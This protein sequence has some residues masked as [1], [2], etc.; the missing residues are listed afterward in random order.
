MDE[1]SCL[2]CYHCEK[3]VAGHVTA[4]MYLRAK[5]EGRIPEEWFTSAGVNCVDCY[6][7]QKCVTDQQGRGSQGLPE[8]SYFL[9]LTNDCNLRC[10]YCYATKKPIV[11]T[12]AMLEQLRIFLTEEEDKRLGDHSLNIQFF[13]GEPTIEWE[14]LTWFVENFSAY[15][16]KLHP[17]RKVRWGMTTNATLLNSERLEFLKKWNMQPLLS[18][19]GRPETHDHHRKTVGGGGSHHLIPLDLILKYFP[20]PEIR[21]TITPDTIEDW[22]ADLRWFH[23]KGLYIV[24]TE[25]AYEADWTDEK[26]EIARQVYKKLADI[27]VERRR[28]GL[29]VWMKFIEDGL[30]FLSSDK[31]T[32]YVCGIA[33]GLMAIDASG[34]IY[35]CQRYASFSRPE[36]A[37]GDIW[38][39]FDEHKLAWTQELKREDMFPDPKSGFNCDDCIA[40]WSCR[41]GCNAMNFQC[42]GDRRM[43]L[44]SHC[45][46]HRMWAEIALIALARTGELWGKKYNKQSACEDQP[47][48]EKVDETNV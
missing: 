47:K 26:M 7:C 45:K 3:G 9:F 38:K 36:L 23:D 20:T 30:G 8:V 15:Y 19:D 40:R 27:Y 14:N 35:A 43:I 4:E 12:H 29:P 18:I 39:G 13:G 32:G 21:P 25:V 33:R 24:A 42:N 48:K 31:Q 17:G 37:I 28:A 2:N 41:G 5:A 6:Q 34:K 1:K 44:A 16:K 22:V 46:F 10:T 11:A